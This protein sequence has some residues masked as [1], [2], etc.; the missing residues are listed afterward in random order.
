MEP[1]FSMFNKILL[2]I[3]LN[4]ICWSMGLLDLVIWICFLSYLERSNSSMC[5][6][7]NLQRQGSTALFGTLSM[8]ITS[9]IECC[10]FHLPHSWT[11]KIGPY[12]V[13]D[14]LNPTTWLANQIQSFIVEWLCGDH[15]TLVTHANV[16]VPNPFSGFVGC[17]SSKVQCTGP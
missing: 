4:F 12:K 3:G 6:S 10:L 16:Q 14:Y 5:N 13:R 1:L 8:L 7:Y 17:T 9:K 15:L 11:W 2:F